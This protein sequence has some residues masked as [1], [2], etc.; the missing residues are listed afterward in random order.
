MNE[1]GGDLAALQALLDR[2]YRAAGEHLRGIH[3][4]GRRM[5]AR[6]VAARLQGMRLLV[7]A[8]VTAGGR[9]LTGA[10][11]GIFHRG[12]FC[13]GTGAGAVRARHLRRNP[14]VSATHLPGEDWAVTV[15]GRAVPAGTGR[16][17]PGGL[18]SALLE[19]YVPRYGPQWEDFLDSGPVYFRIEADRMFA[20]DVTA[21]SPEYSA[22][23]A[24]GPG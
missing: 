20:I 9:P 4:G 22:S 24:A 19:V 14:A 8:T 16:D 23:P 17:D 21:G 13:F 5:T 3:T 12:S 6:Q 1:T 7:V 10:V 18:R 11:D 15:H 2:S